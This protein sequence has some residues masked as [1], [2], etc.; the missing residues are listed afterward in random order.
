LRETSE[1]ARFWSAPSF[2]LPC[3]SAFSLTPIQQGRELIVRRCCVLGLLSSSTPQRGFVVFLVTL[4]LY[5][6]L[7]A[8]VPRAAHRRHLV[9]VVLHAHWRQKGD[10]GGDHGGSPYYS[11]RLRSILRSGLPFLCT[12]A[13]WICRAPRNCFQAL[14]CDLVFFGMV[15]SIAL[16]RPGMPPWPGDDA[17]GIL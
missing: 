2:L 11:I 16:R 10:A 7:L 5:P 3:S 9:V 14:T 6:A 13:L 15:S 8:K 1:Q 4:F 17:F 12:S